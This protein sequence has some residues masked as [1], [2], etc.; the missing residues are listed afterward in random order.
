MVFDALRR[1]CFVFDRV[2]NKVE[3]VVTL[4]FAFRFVRDP[5]YLAPE[6]FAQD[7]AFKA[8]VEA[9]S[10]P[11]ESEIT[12]PANPKSCVWSFG[13]ILLEL[14]LVNRWRRKTTKFIEILLGKT[15]LRQTKRHNSDFDTYSMFKI[16]HSKC[17]RHHSS[18]KWFWSR[19][20]F[21]NKNESI[22]FTIDQ[23]MSRCKSSRKVRFDR[24]R[25]T[26]IS[27]IVVEPLD[28]D[29]F[30]LTQN[31]K[32]A[33][34][35]KFLREKQTI[36]MIWDE[37]ETKRNTLLIFRPTFVELLE[38]LGG[39]RYVTPIQR[40][41]TLT[42]FNGITPVLDHNLD[43]TD[44][45]NL[46]GSTSFFFHFDKTKKTKNLTFFSFSRTVELSNDRS[47]FLSLAISWWRFDGCFEKRWSHQ[48]FTI[49]RQHFEVQQRKLNVFSILSL[50]IRFV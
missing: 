26:D 4:S 27:T 33:K 48:N 21:N 16:E 12:D 28:F 22:L 14:C 50:K 31:I 46:D 2:K 6:C 5:S 41:L 7:L 15:T 10:S 8:L 9:S 18:T 20:T 47:N 23:K 19:R 42:L 30:R 11:Y 49:D 3:N 17:F 25:F 36:D 40:S 45:K 24:N 32:E 34:P 29:R 13:L 1:L 35:M 37:L 38:E 43:L 44:F 39:K